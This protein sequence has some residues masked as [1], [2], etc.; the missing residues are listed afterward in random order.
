[1]ISLISDPQRE[2]LL[3]IDGPTGKLQL[4]VATPKAQ[5]IQTTAVICHPHP[6]QGGTMTNKV[7]TTLER[8]FAELGADTVRFNFRGVGESEGKHDNAEG[9][10]DD[11]TAVVNWAKQRSPNHQ[12]WLAGFSFGSVVATRFVAQQSADLLVTVAP[13]VNRYDFPATQNI[14][15]P[16]V[17]VQGGQDDV[18]PLEAVQQWRQQI[19]PAPHWILFEKTGHFFHGQLVALKAEL[20]KTIEQIRC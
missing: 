14:N 17:I 11:L 9:E 16:W 1:M 7:V 13:P 12:L 4:I 18:V 3:Q 20:T 15:C 5:S 10:V 8:C 19:S 6:L 2:E